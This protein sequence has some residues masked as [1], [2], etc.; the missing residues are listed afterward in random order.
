MGVAPLATP[1]VEYLHCILVTDGVVS[2][3]PQPAAE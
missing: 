1:L 2:L 3:E